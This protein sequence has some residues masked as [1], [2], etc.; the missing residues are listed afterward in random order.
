MRIALLVALAALAVYLSSFRTIQHLDAST[1]TLMSYTFVRDGDPFL[2]EFRADYDRISYW[3]YV[4]RG[5]EV[6][7]YQPGASM[8]AAPFVALGLLLGIEPPAAASVT[9]VGK[10]A[11]AVAAAASVLF[12]CLT[13]GRFAG[14]RI[15]VLIGALYALGTVTWPVS[16]GALWQHGPA[17]LFVSLGLYQL[18]SRDPLW[19]AR[20][21]LAFGLA[22]LTRYHTGIFWLAAAFTLGRA[23][24]PGLLRFLAWSVPAAVLKVSYDLAGFGQIVTRFT[25]YTEETDVLGAMG[26]A[27]DFSASH[28]LLSIGV[29]GLGHLISP[30]RGLFVYSP[31]LIV[32]AYELIRR[33]VRRDRGWE[34]IAPQ[35]VGAL[36]IWA[37]YSVFREWHGGH[38]YGNR[39]L[40]ETLPLLALGT[41]LWAQRLSSLPWTTRF[42]TVT[43]S[44]AIAV[45]ALGATVYDWE[46]WSWEM[47]APAADRV[48]RLDIWQPLFTAVHA[49]QH[50]DALTPITVALVGAV[51]VFLVR[52]W[53]V[54]GTTDTAR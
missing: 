33:T 47:L 46:E 7:S 49:P 11:A 21:G 42:L 34:V 2:D 54:T 37:L 14:P 5:R 4:V 29:A 24:R 26:S 9:V 20:S 18:T 45:M 10:T 35:L 44:F 19:R 1:Y 53:S 6:G 50:W 25:P 15:V 27:V 40:S 31:F 51:L 28:D 36:G 32:G 22:A 38:G 43:G 39:Y 17:Q 41:A 8:F 30:S 48:W 3:P 16:G 52:L 23:D 12:V 13:I